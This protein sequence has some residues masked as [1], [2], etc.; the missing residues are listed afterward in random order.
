MNKKK[1]IIVSIGRGVLGKVNAYKTMVQLLYDIL[2]AIFT[3]GRKSVPIKQLVNQILFIGVDAFIISISIALV[4]GIL[5]TFFSFENMD[6]FGA[7]NKY[8]LLMVVSII[9][10]LGPFISAIVVIGRSGT[11]LTAFLGNMKVTKEI[12]ALNS[13]GIDIVEY[14]L[15]PAFL[16][17]I[18][19]LIALNFYFDIVALFGGVLFAK[20]YYGVSYTVYIVQ[21]INAIV[22][23]DI[24]LAII[25][26]LIFGSIIAVVSSYNGIVVNSVR[27]V[28][29]AVYRSAV[30]ATSFIFF[31]NIILSMVYYGIRS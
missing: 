3:K 6:D 24:P 28:P 21:I 22:Y 19:S 2:V 17:M 18:I 10:E 29:R 8:G 16:A 15:L 12:D 1:N 20:V 5:L 27:I 9:I 30:T 11:A 13:M 26:S 7:S 14:L 4:L 25:K 23:S 31:F